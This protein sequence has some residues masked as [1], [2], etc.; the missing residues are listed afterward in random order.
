MNEM[1]VIC[2]RSLVTGYTECGTE[3]FPR[4]LAVK[5][6]DELNKR[7]K[8]LIQHWVKISP[9]ADGPTY[10]IGGDA[11]Q[12]KDFTTIDTFRTD[13]HPMRRVWSMAKRS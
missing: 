7:W 2:H 9:P 10:S 6:A 3:V 5:N 12:K 4:A 8:G 13:V 11:A 1:Y